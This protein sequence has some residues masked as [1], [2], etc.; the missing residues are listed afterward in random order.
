MRRGQ[1][2]TWAILVTA[3]AFGASGARRTIQATVV[4]AAAGIRMVTWREVI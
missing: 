2:G 4:R 1:S 3:Q